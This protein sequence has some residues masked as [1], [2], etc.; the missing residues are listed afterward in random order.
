MARPTGLFVILAL[1][2]LAAPLTA[3]VQ[4]SAKV[5]RL[6]VLFPASPPSAADWQ[7]QSPFWTHFWQGMRE[8]G[9]IEGQNILV[10][11]RWAEQRLGRLP[12]LATELVQLQVDVILGRGGDQIAAAKQAT[13]T[14]PIVMAPAL[15]AVGQ[16]FVASL[17]RP[18]GN[19]TGLT[20]ISPDLMA[21]RLELL[22]E[23][24]PGVSRVAVLRC[25]GMMGG[26]GWSELQDAAHGFGVPLL[27]LEVQE[28]GDYAEAFA[29][30]IR[31][32][33]AAMV[34]PQCYFHSFNWRRVIDLA[35]QH[36]LPAIY[37]GREWVSRGGFLSYGPSPAA[38]GHRAATYVD[39]IL[40]G[41]KPADLPVELPMTFELVIN[42]KTAQT[43]G[44]TI[45]PLLLFQATEVIR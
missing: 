34:V 37:T 27:S 13:Q 43:L 14:L 5:Y 3:D 28:P 6:G 45:P 44:L 11:R 15:D 10:E 18:G 32:R 41:A 2:M 31:E 23:A 36:R 22:K 1:G 24:V 30:A 19:V 40:K 33:A 17:A 20:V 26:Q 8:L 16:G 9:W 4:P 7:Q 29:A 42:L 38:I 21:K 25:R 12:A 35:A 39:K